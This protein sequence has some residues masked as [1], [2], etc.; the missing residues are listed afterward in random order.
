MKK[1]IYAISKVGKNELNKASGIGYIT[2]EDIITACVTKQGKPYIRVFENAVKSC[3]RI[4]NTENEYKGIYYEIVEVPKDDG[5][6]R[7]IEIDY[8]IW[9]K[10]VD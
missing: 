2:D 7:E 4:A 6:S 8:L 9:Y 3:H 10:L 1:I 5:T